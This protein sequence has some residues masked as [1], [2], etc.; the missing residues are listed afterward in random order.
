MSDG[1]A[2]FPPTP[3]DEDLPP[4]SNGWKR[5]MGFGSVGQ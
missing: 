4:L 3:R 2:A 1:R 5:K